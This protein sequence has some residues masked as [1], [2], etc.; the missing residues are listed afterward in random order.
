[1]S[2][3]RQDP[4]SGDWIILA[5]GRATRPHFLDVKKKPRKPSPKSSCP[6]EN[7]E[8]GED[9]PPIL[10][11]PN[12]KN[13]K[14]ALVPNK[15]PALTHGN[16]CA[17]LMHHGMYNMMAG[18]GSHDLLISRDHNKNFAELDPKLA[19]KLLEMLQ[20]RHRMMAQDPCSA[21]VSSFFN[22][23]LTAGASVGHPHY[24]TLT[25]P[26]IPPHN[27]RSLQEEKKYFERHHRCV[28][29][30]VI[31]T[32]RKEK[33]R[34]IEENKYAIAIAPFASKQPFEVSILPKEHDSHF[35]T[36]S[37]ATIRAIAPM[38]QS[39]MRRIKKYLNDPDLNFFIH[40]APL[41]KD[42]YPYHHWHIEVMPKVSIPAGFELSTGIDINIVDP[43]MAAKMLRGEK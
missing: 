24:Q 33:K 29:C 20:E 40:G 11:Y 31:K 15:Y 6:F 2:E 17:V 27:A 26:I 25:L 8:K 42:Q 36:T 30:D 21:Y 1:M 28:R 41:G 39:M 10:A 13:W 34:I 37:P 16:V 12:V 22:W 35:G 38:L 23:G 3:L 43:D 4:S 18:I 19:V 5:P 9:W 32:E 14:L 7:L